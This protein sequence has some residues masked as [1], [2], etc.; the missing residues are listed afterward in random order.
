[1][2]AAQSG[3]AA[4]AAEIDSTALSLAEVIDKIVRMASCRTPR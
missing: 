3:K 2:D 4:D 1:M